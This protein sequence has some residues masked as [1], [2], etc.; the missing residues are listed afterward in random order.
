MLNKY[1]LCVA[2][3]HVNGKQLTVTWHVDN[4][5]ISNVDASVVDNVIRMLNEEF[6]KES[7]MN[8]SRGKVH[9]YLGMTLDYSDPGKIIIYMAYY[10]REC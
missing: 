1:D 8:I 7:N 3:K 9:D 2:N 10:I 5:K 6:G 4:L